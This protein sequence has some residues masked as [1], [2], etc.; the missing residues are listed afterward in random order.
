MEDVWPAVAC[1]L[2]GMLR[3][4]G[5][6]PATA[7]DLAQETALRALRAGVDFEN[8]DDLFRWAAVVGWRLAIDARRRQARIDP[9]P[10]PDRQSPTNVALVVE[11][12]S[13]L[14]AVGAGLRSL[15]PLDRHAILSPSGGARLSRQESVRLKVRRHRARARLQALVEGL[16]GIGTWLA[17]RRRATLLPRTTLTAALVT[18]TLGVALVLLP[19][20]DR[21]PPAGQVVGT[22]EF[23]APPPASPP[24]VVVA[25]GPS[26][27]AAAAMPIAPAPPALSRPGH[28]QAE[29]PNV[30]TAALPATHVAVARPDGGRS[31]VGGRPNEPNEELVCLTVTRELCVEQPVEPLPALPGP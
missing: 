16:A 6:D 7:E 19:N 27:P 10:V 3:H 15:S 22:R 20:L 29:R 24:T 9:V 26:V 5:I 21:R 11:Q 17:E 31:S 4:R 13:T 1:R 14:E 25:S 28:S 23:R 18:P 2:T 8:A 30:P 12:R